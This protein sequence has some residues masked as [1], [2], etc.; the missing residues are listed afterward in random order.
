MF[1]PRAQCANYSFYVHVQVDQVVEIAITA[2]FSQLGSTVT[3]YGEVG[4]ARRQC[5]WGLIVVVMNPLK[6]FMFNQE[7]RSWPLDMM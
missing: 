1:T 2:V 5:Q 6:V 7:R 4:T 3:S